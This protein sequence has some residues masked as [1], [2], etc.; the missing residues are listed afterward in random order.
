VLQQDSV[1]AVAITMRGAGRR[2]G[3]LT[4]E[5]DAGCSRTDGSV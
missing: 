2:V 1:S 3:I 4:G 5:R